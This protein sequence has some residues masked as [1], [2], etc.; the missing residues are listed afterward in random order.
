MSNFLLNLVVALHL[1]D[2]IH[3]PSA[4]VGAAGPRLSLPGQGR[5]PERRDAGTRP[6]MGTL[7]APLGQ[8]RGLP[9][10]AQVG[11]ATDAM[12][13]PLGLHKRV[14]RPAARLIAPRA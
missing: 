13:T 8:P 4:G 5:S 2:S 11:M 6:E 9:Q 1:R 14:R 12:K 3:G 7:M 10:R